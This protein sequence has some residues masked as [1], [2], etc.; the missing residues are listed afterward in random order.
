MERGRRVS[1]KRRSVETGNSLT[2]KQ[3]SGVQSNKKEG[4]LCYIVVYNRTPLTKEDNITRMRYGMPF[5]ASKNKIA[6]Q[7]TDF[8]PTGDVL[9]DLFAGG[10]A[11]THAA[12]LAGK[13]KR[14]MAN[15]IGG[16]PEIFKMAINGDFREYQTVPTR[17]EFH[18][19][20]YDDPVMRILY[21]FGNNG[22]S[23]LWPKDI[24]ALKVW[25]S[26]TVS[27]PSL[28]ERRIAFKRMIS[29]LANY[30]SENGL[31]NPM[32]LQGLKRLQGLQGLERL[33]GLQGLERLQDTVSLET[34]SEDYKNI[35]IP[36]GAI[37]YADPPYRGTETFYGID[38]DFT[39][40]D[41]W[42]NNVDFPV[43]VS[44]YTCPAGCV[45]VA[46]FDRFGTMRSN[47]KKVAEK[48][49]VQERYI[50]EL[51]LQCRR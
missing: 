51:P 31:D 10:C 42:L 35:K 39:A 20:K 4:I 24:E 41:E 45:E 22:R 32:R 50:S 25:A 29:E 27:A 15:D 49:F 36:S 16:W 8:L 5:Q 46:T 40:F 17:E 3:K 18:K 14:I 48:I 11:I 9:V 1:A 34:Y 19:Q 33:Q 23:Y 21:S 12:L 38:F 7:I 44:E 26:R 43:Y 6:K 2:K 13:W 30:I 28:Y 47:H 37:V